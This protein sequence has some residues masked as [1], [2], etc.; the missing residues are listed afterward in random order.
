MAFVAVQVQDKSD[1]AVVLHDATPALEVV[2]IAR[3]AINEEIHLTIG[4]VG[5]DLVLDQ[6]HRDL[7][8][9]DLTLADVVF[10]Q[11]A[12]LA[13]LLTLCTQEITCGKVNKSIV[14]DDSVALCTLT[15]ARASQDENDLGLLQGVGG[16]SA[17]W[18]KG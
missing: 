9:N 1:L 5:H 11:L 15:S 18:T 7:N 3:E 14:T 8:G 4:N 2:L 17:D 6:V 12:D 13:T 16:G 10:D